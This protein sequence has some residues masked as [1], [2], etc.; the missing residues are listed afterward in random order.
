MAGSSRKLEQRITVSLPKSDYDALSSIA[1]NS[2]ASMSWVVRHAVAEFLRSRRAAQSSP[3][4]MPR[5]G[6][7]R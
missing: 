2:D 3:K 6:A 4:V 5:I 1:E 7:L